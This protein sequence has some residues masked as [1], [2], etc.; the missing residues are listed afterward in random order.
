M[1]CLCVARCVPCPDGQYVESSTSQCVDCPLGTVLPSS[2]SWGRD[3]CRACGDGLKAMDRRECKSDC[4][5]TDKSGRLYDF[6]ALDGS[7]ILSNFI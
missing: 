2:N 6:T 7:V 1:Y 3:S 4:R 5:F